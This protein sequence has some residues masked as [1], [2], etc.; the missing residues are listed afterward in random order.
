MLIEYTFQGIQFEW[1]RHKAD[2]NLKKHAISFETACEAFLDPF[3]Q[4]IDVEEVDED[5]REAIIGMTISW[6][7]LCVVYTI[8]NEEIFR[9]ISA[10]SVTKME[11]KKYEEY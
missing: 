2:I 11:R 3:V 9:I 1:D 10:R 6:K 8:R 4:S 5:L 7:L